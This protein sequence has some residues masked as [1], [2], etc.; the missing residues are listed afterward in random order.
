MFPTPVLSKSLMQL[1]SLKG[2]AM[3]S[4]KS[5]PCLSVLS[6][7]L[8]MSYLPQAAAQSSDLKA[9]VASSCNIKGTLTLTVL[10]I[11][12]TRVLTCLNPTEQSHRAGGDDSSITG[13]L[14]AGVPGLVNLA[15]VKAPYG[16]S[17]YSI[18]P[19]TTVLTVHAGA[20]E[21]SLIQN[22]IQ[23]SGVDGS[24]ECVASTGDNIVHCA[25]DMTL[26]NLTVNGQPVQIPA[27]PIPFNSRIA[28]ADLHIQVEVLG[29]GLVDIPLSGYMYLNRIRI[30]SDSSSQMQL[31]HSPL[32]VELQGHVSVLGIGLVDA[33]IS[34][35]DYGETRIRN[36]S[37]GQGMTVSSQSCN[38]ANCEL[39]Y[40]NTNSKQNTWCVAKD[41]APDT[42]LQAAIDWGCGLGTVDCRPIEENGACYSPDALKDHASYVLNSYYQKNGQNT[43]A[44]DFPGAAMI[45]ASDP[46]T[47]TCQY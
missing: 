1:I 29:I 47:A 37:T 8:L 12:S 22:Q 31:K 13:D 10:G 15:S 39:S 42:M 20:D 3:N 27:S 35:D 46:S 44:C 28:I 21:I 30:Q 19:G 7:V 38:N 33:R 6:F 18:L 23:S 11:A 41:G 43:M 34:L 5:L 45:T 36:A 40:P 32:S 2:K 14:I 17:D 24:T 16:Q 9:G 4:N 26:A 25:V